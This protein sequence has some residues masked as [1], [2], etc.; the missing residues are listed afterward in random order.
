MRGPAGWRC[1][2]EPPTTSIAAGPELG[3][4]W[5]PEVGRTGWPELRP[6]RWPELRPDPVART[7]H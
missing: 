3:R 7:E 4:T 1:T 2:A 6:D 5:W